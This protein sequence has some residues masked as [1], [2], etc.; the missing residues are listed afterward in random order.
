MKRVEIEKQAIVKALETAPNVTA[1]ARQLGASRRTLQSRMRDYALPEGEPGR[2]RELLP[3][4]GSAFPEALSTVA[5]IGAAFG[6]GY[7]VWRRN[8]EQVVGGGKPECL[9][10]LDVI[11]RKR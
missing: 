3:Y 4:S 10:G 2:P 8:K 9:R 7:W 1:A 11:S 5:V 6:L